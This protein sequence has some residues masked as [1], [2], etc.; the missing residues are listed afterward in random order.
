M[1]AGVACKCVTVAVEDK[2]ANN[3]HQEH[4]AMSENQATKR[5]ANTKTKDV[6]TAIATTYIVSYAEQHKST[7]QI[8]KIGKKINNIKLQNEQVGIQA[9]KRN[10]KRHFTTHMK[11]ST[12]DVITRGGV[13]W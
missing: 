9:E 11:N 3:A 13:L 6:A 5:V 12:S 4:V 8:S 1:N 7:L 10:D 2:T